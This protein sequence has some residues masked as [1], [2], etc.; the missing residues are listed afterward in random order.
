MCVCVFVT[1]LLDGDLLLASCSQDCLIRV[2]RLVVKCDTHSEQPAEEIIRMKEDVF[3]V[4]GKGV[5]L[6]LLL[7]VW[8]KFDA[9]C[10]FPVM[11]LFL[12]STSA[13]CESRDGFSWP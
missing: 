5:R 13:C 7:S 11:N 4:K 12:F 10:C 2:W 6:S 9:E 3:E 8:V 1:S